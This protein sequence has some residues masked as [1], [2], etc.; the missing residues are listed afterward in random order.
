MPPEG[1]RERASILKALP[2]KAI[3]K[4]KHQLYTEVDL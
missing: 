2:Y 4:R 1:S 3:S